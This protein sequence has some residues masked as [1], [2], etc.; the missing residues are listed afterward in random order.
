[1]KHPFFEELIPYAQEMQR[2]TGIP[3]SVALAQAALESGFGK[4]LLSK[5]AKNLF[6]VKA[7]RSWKGETIS[8]PTTE[9]Y[10]GKP[11]RV[12]ARWRKY[13]S[14]LDAFLDLAKVY[15]N[16]LYDEALP[17]RR[18]PREFIHRAGKVYAT[19]PNYAEKVIALIDR[20][21]LDKYDIPPEQWALDQKLVPK[22]WYQAWAKL[23]GEEVRV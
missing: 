17:Y 23:Y 7:G 10:Q 22:T 13:N 16:G 3:A 19:D 20:Y 18:D 12:M 5:Q 14:Y 4:S 21:Q 11:V 1:M 8:L 15:Y 6:G 2:R 9:Y